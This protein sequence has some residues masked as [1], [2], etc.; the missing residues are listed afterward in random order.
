MLHAGLALGAYEIQ[1]LMRQ[2]GQNLKPP[3]IYRALDFL[4]TFGLAHRIES[5]NAYIACAHCGDAFHQP[6]FM[7]CRMCGQV[8]EV[9]LPQ[10]PHERCHGEAQN[11]RIERTVYEVQGVCENCYQVGKV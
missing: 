3:T 10:V 7:I 5:L 11:F 6:G 1:A 9:V 2:N 8:E 4:T